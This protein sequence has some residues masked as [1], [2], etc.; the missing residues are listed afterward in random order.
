[1]RVIEYQ[2]LEDRPVRSRTYPGLSPRERIQNSE[3]A[4]I[5]YNHRHKMIM[6]G[7]QK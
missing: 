4:K 1:M 3:I 2:T 6:F 5:M 7:D